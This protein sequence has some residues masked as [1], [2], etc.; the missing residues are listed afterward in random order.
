MGN[1]NRDLQSIFLSN[2]QIIEQHAFPMKSQ[3]KTHIQVSY[4]FSLT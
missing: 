2:F 1:N 3:K 4:C